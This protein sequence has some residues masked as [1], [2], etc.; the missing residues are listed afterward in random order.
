MKRFTSK[1]PVKGKDQLI[2]TLNTS[3]D[4]SFDLVLSTC[5]TSYIKRDNI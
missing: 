5:I 2:L 4:N 3:E 1:W